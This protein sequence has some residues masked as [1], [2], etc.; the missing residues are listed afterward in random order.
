[1]SLLSQ[2]KTPHRT[3]KRKLLSNSSEASS[4]ITQL[5]R[6]YQPFPRPRHRTPDANTSLLIKHHLAF[7]PLL[8]LV[9]CMWVIYRYLFHF[10]VWFDE[11][12]G[13]AVFFG[14]PVGL[15]LSLTHS[16]RMMETLEP[17]AVQPGLW[18]G[19]AVGGIFGFAG[20]LA[21]LLKSR[22]IVQA[23]PLFAATAFWQQFGLAMMTGFWESLFFYGWVMVVVREKFCTWPLLNQCLLT[24]GV[25]LVFHLPNTLLRY[26]AGDIGGQLALLFFF[27][28]G[29]AFLFARTRNIY[30][31]AMSHAIWGMVLLIHTR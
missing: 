4:G 22:V 15:Y 9:F 20:T 27:A 5:H 31:L 25:F 3:N 26:S 14:L 19:L 13:K 10:P 1:M 6:Q 28:L 21:S 29:Q 30:A 23:A 7:F 18:M 16:E 2:A 8:F 17:N 12:I 11:S 24:A